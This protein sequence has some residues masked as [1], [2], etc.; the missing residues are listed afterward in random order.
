MK[1]HPI[2]ADSLKTATDKATDTRRTS[3][4]HQWQFLLES[5]QSRD[6]RFF[7]EGRLTTQHVTKLRVKLKFCL[8]PRKVLII[9][10]PK[11]EEDEEAVAVYL[12]D[13]EEPQRAGACG[14]K[15]A[16]E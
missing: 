13:S 11:D 5:D 16:F 15:D 1:E 8:E 6:L 3:R 2:R 14:A 10:K 4:G 9:K 12:Q 7:K